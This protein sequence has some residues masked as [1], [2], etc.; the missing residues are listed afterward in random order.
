MNNIDRMEITRVV[1]AHRLST[2]RNADHIYVLQHGKI[3]QHGTYDA[4]VAVE[5]TFQNLVKRQMS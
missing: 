3:V 4:L 2:I 1:I 5:G